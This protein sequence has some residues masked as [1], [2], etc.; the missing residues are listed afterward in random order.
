LHGFDD[1]HGGLP[2]T[3]DTSHEHHA[4]WVRFLP[5]LGPT[6]FRPFAVELVINL[7]DSVCMGQINPGLIDGQNIS[8]FG[9]VD[10]AQKPETSLQP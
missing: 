6:I 2:S 7:P 4:L 9:A 3:A 8:P 10:V 1:T 5:K